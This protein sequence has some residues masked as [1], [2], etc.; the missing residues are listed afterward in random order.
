MRTSLLLVVLLIAPAAHAQSRPLDAVEGDRLRIT[1]HLE[2]V[3]ATLLAADISHLSAEQRAARARNVERLRA[4]RMR[5]EFPHG[6]AGQP[7]PRV[8]TFI[9]ADGRA[10]AMGQ[11]VIESGHADVAEAIARAQ[12]HAR[13]PEI[14]HRALAPWLVA[15]GMT[16]EEATLVQPSYC[17]ECAEP[18]DQPVCGSDGHAYTAQCVAECEGVT[19]VGPAS[20]TDGVC[21][22]DDAGTSADAGGVTRIDGGGGTV[23]PRDRGGCNAGG[24]GHESLPAALALVFVLA[25]S[26]RRRAVRVTPRR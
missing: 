5:G 18:G 6:Y 2:R 16:L 3:E 10:C 20:C 12:N 26:R 25:S 21:T 15:N 23:A 22:C 19:A 8:P 13:V 7:G 1:A 4:Y 9:D 17:F 24:A 11:L 14:T